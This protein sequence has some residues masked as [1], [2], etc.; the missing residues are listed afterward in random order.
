MIHAKFSQ[1]LTEYEREE[2]L[3][4]NEIY[5]FGINAVKEVPKLDTEES[6]SEE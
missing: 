3:K 6:I 2:I 5:C 1:Y 4:Y